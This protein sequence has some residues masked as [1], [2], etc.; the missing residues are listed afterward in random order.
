MVILLCRKD[1]AE[2]KLT[3]LIKEKDEQIVG[4]MA[5][6]GIQCKC[7]STFSELFRRKVVKTRA[8]I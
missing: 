4:L 1:N 3:E 6:G 2:L 8:A 5:E 7:L